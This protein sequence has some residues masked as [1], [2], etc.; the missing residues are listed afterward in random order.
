MS[1]PSAICPICLAVLLRDE[2]YNP[3]ASD[4]ERHYWWHKLEALAV[5]M[6]EKILNN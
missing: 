6:G 4:V 1:V 5:E 3:V 2:H